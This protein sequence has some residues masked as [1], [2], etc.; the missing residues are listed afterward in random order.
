MRLYVSLAAAGA[1]TPPLS[2]FSLTSLDRSF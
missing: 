2:L 1:A